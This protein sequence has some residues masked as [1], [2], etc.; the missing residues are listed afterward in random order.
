MKQVDIAYIAGL[1]DGEGYIGIKKI[2]VINAK[3]EKHPAIMPVFKFAWLTNQRLNLFL[4]LSV[5]G[6]IKKSQAAKMVVH[7]FVIKHPIKE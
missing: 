1:I 5:G 4:N 3:K 7:C 2:K 6:T